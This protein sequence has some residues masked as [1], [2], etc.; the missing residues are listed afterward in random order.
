MQLALLKLL[1]LQGASSSMRSLRHARATL[2]SQLLLVSLRH[3]PSFLAP[4]SLRCR[5]DGESGEISPFGGLLCR[6]ACCGHAHGPDSS[7]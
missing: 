3:S 7:T 4:E 1:S 6:R 5:L 2:M